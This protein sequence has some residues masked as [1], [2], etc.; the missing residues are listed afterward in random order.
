MQ[1]YAI[2]A[3]RDGFRRAGRTWSREAEV[4]PAGE[5]GE[6]ALEALRA[7]PNITVTPCAADGPVPAAG[8]AS[9]APRPS[10]AEVARAMSVE[11]LR[12]ALIHVAMRGLEPANADHFTAA[13]LPVAAALQQATGLR[14]ISAAERDEIWPDVQ[15]ERAAAGS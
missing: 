5:L 13:G 8:G 12:A 1:H 10:D 15:A 4:V 14:S 3:T 2:S 11:E 7:D 9:A 6:A